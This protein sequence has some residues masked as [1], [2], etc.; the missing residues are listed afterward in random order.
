[1]IPYA[2]ALLILL[3]TILN[4]PQERDPSEGPVPRLDTCLCML[5]SMTTLAIACIIDE[6][7][8]FP[9]DEADHLSKYPRK[10][11]QGLGKRK[12][13]LI[14]SL[15]QLGD[16][17]SLIAPPQSVC[18]VANQAAAKALMFISG[19]TSGNGFYECISMNDMPINCCKF[20]ILRKH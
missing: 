1:M 20:F 17:E 8:A 12:K 2:F 15:Q 13:D 4:V 18:S 9:L 19:L 3:G 5:L 11:K 10:E 16:Y 14:T 6:E 7:E